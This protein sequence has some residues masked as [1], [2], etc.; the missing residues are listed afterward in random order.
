MQGLKNSSIIIPMFN[1]QILA[2]NSLWSYLKFDVSFFQVSSFRNSCPACVSASIIC[3]HVLNQ[4][5]VRFN[6]ITIP[7]KNVNK[8][9]I[10]H[11]DNTEI[12]T[13]PRAIHQDTVL[14]DI[15]EVKQKFVLAKTTNPKKIK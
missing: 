15:A 14:G 12:E 2:L 13:M 9:L 3:G 10:L 7:Y 4:Q 1:I 8:E 6:H 11:R 5:T